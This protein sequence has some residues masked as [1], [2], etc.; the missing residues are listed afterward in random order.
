MSS[1]GPNCP[2]K[3]RNF[4]AENGTASIARRRF[5]EKKKVLVIGTETRYYVAGEVLA[6]R[7]RERE[8]EREEEYE[9]A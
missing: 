4:L 8:R 6:N 7:E 5:I 3:P 2:T 9:S 1:Y